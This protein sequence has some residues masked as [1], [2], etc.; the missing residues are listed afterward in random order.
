MKVR[1][2]FTV[3]IDHEAWALAYGYDSTDKTAIREDVKNYVS[4]GSIAHLEG[5]GFLRE[6]A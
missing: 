5:L 1:I 2:E 4:Q 3:D 6:Q